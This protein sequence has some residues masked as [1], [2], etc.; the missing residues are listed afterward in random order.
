MTTDDEASSAGVSRVDPAVLQA[1]AESIVAALGARQQVAASVAESLVDADLRGHGSHGVNRLPQYAE[2]V[3]DGA[4]DPTGEPRLEETA[5]A[6]AHVDGR[7]TFGQHTG[8]LATDRAIELAHDQGI[9]VVGVRNGSH[10]GR[11]GEWA[12]RAASADVLFLAFVNTQGG[13]LTVAPP[14]SAERVLS[15]N[16]IAAG[17]PS[18]GALPFPIVF[19]GATSQ[20]AN[21]K[22][23][24]RRRTG[25]PVPDAW[26]TTPS[27]EPITDADRF[28]EPNV[29]AALLPLGG[30]TAGHKGFGLGIV[31]ELLA[32]L[33]GDGAV[34]GGSEPAWFDNAAT[35][36]AVDP[37]RF[38]THQAAADRVSTLADH[39][40]GAELGEDDVE[41]AAARPD[42]DRPLL[43]GEPESVT[44]ARRRERGVPLHDG[45]LTP[46]LDLAEELDVGVPSGLDR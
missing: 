3:A 15:T 7:S 13:A 4:I 20:V 9:G 33:V 44:A 27:G 12:E 37:L 5:P 22:L 40:R 21:G 18:F 23:R 45:V 8:R 25:D 42:D 38:T 16:P 26:T 17:I 19:D 34:A 14:R 24:E 1:V 6:A 11:V 31:A 43:P 32:G 30:R 10:L 28:F 2:M 29:S 46:V 36:V 35:F 41:S 39:V